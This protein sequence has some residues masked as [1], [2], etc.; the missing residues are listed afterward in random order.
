MIYPNN[1]NWTGSTLTFQYDEAIADG[2]W[3]EFKP[4]SGNDFIT[5]IKVEGSCPKSCNLDPN[6]YG[7]SGEVQGVVKPK[8]GSGF[9]PTGGKTNITN[10]PVKNNFSCY[11][12]NA[13]V[14]KNILPLLLPFVKDT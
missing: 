11:V 8:T 14:Y 5:I 2:V 4:T 1:Y 12:S 7:N 9:P 3:V 6:F 10:Q 13:R